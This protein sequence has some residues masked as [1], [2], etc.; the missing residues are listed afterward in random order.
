MTTIQDL[1]AAAA[2]AEDWV[3]DLAQ[4]LGWRDRQ[5]VYLA[6]LGA[7]HALRDCLA[8]DEAVYLGEHLPPLLRGLYYEGWHPGGIRSAKSRTAFLERIHEGVHRDP[9][10]DAEQ[11]AR[12]VFS[13]LVAR[14]PPAEVED[15]KA[16]MPTALH[17][18]WPS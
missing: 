1:S 3:D 2:A 5:R 7:L 8:G 4:R 15:A 13:L 14:L 10:I 12:A 17:N 11:V 16:A 18:L 9:G 6:L